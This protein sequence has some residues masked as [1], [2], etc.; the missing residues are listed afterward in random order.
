MSQIV[1]FAGANHTYTAPN[2]NDLP[3][4]VGTDSGMPVIVSCWQL[5]VNELRHIIEH[6]GKVYLHVYGGGQPPVYVSPIPVADSVDGVPT[7]WVLCSRAMLA[8]DDVRDALFDNFKLLAD[9]TQVA[10]KDYFCRL[11][12]ASHLFRHGNVQYEI[13]FERLRNGKLAVKEVVPVQGE[14]V[15]EDQG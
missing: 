13:N 3:T 9:I 1:K 2:C 11:M 10:E 8:E 14:T 15:A 5:D 4:M 7:G 6:G 12:F